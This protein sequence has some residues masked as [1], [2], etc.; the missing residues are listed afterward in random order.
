V[1]FTFQSTAIE[2]LPVPRIRT[3]FTGA[4]EALRSAGQLRAGLL[5]SPATDDPQ[6]IIAQSE[7]VVIGA[8]CGRAGPFQ[9]RPQAGPAGSRN[10]AHQR[11]AGGADRFSAV[12]R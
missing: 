5:R 6:R 11:P 2:R 10:A 9:G 4:Q 3:P 1:G 12:R 8:S 7:V